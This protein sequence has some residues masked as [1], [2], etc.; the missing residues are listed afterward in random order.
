MAIGY[1]EFIYF[2]DRSHIALELF[3]AAWHLT[4]S[5]RFCPLLLD[6]EDVSSKVLDISTVSSSYTYDK[7]YSVPYIKQVYTGVSA[8]QRQKRELNICRLYLE[9]REFEETT[10]EDSRPTKPSADHEIR[11]N[12]NR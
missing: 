10:G 11:R 12:D 5:E 1:Y 9:M 6:L 7:V 2:Q 8:P 4:V 3:K